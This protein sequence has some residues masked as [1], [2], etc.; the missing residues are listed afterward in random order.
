MTNV[1]GLILIG[2]AALPMLIYP[3]VVLANVMSLAGHRNPDSS[4]IELLPAR[5]F[6][7]VTT[8]YPF[9]LVGAFYL[10]RKKVNILFAVLPYIHIVLIVIAYGMWSTNVRALRSTW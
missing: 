2:I 7:L 9:T 4:F 1:L 8:L 10:F 3:F 5:L 6:I